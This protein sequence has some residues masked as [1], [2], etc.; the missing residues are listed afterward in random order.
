MIT[1]Y[2]F[3]AYF[4]LP[5][6]SPFITKVDILLQM[7]GLDYVV[8]TDGD[9]T[10]APREKYPIIDDNGTIVPDSTSIRFYLE[11]TYNLDFNQHVSAERQAAL[12]GLERTAENEMYFLVLSERWLDDANFN[13]GPVVFFE[14]APALIRPLICKMVRKRIEKTIWLQGLGRL[15]QD[16]QSELVERWVQACA[17]TLGDRAYFGGEEPCAAD[18]TLFAFLIGMDCP[19]FKTSYNN[20]LKAHPALITYCERMMHR[21]YG[22]G[23]N[24]QAQAAA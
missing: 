5:D 3:G 20:I 1:L 15:T 6:A 13:K 21:F 8:K 4:G 19:F 16:E 18:A 10:K 14:K 22:T 7:A 12:W 24:E 11:K 2:G 23:A 9:V 17:N